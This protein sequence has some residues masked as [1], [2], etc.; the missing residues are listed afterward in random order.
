MKAPAP[1]PAGPGA[2]AHGGTRPAGVPGDTA[3]RPR[4]PGAVVT[5]AGGPAGVAV[6]QALVGQGVRVVAVDA[7]PA[8][9]G[10]CLAP[11]AAVVP[12]ATAEGFV[13]ALADLA[14]AR[15][16]DALVPTVA[17]ELPALHA[18]ARLLA[19]AG[20]ATWLP[21]PGA[22]RSCLDKWRFA[23]VMAAGGVPVPPT[24]LPGADGLPA[25]LS[26]AAPGPDG[27]GGLPGPWI[28]KPR[29]G[30]GSRHVLAADDLA[31][32]A[33]ALVLVPEPI[34][35]H[36]AAGREF[37]VDVLAGHDG[38]VGSVAR[39]RDETRGGISTRGE[40]FV[41]AGVDAAV[42]AAVAAAG[43]WGPA[44]V[45]GFA[46]GGDV[47][48]TEINPRFSGGLPLSLA[49]GADLVGEYLR[50]VR[51]Q[52]LRPERLVGRPGVQMRRYFAEVFSTAS[53]AGPGAAAESPRAGETTAAAVPPAAGPGGPG[54]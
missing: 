3:R 4:E 39:W 15:G 1:G 40:T 12:P 33:A 51:G 31:E 41:H 52:P 8:A 19:D 48:I 9:V 23:E 17:E 43:L 44:N 49:A 29:N 20:V 27:W 18:G 35:Q 25:A 21:E 32:L 6:V 34:V 11:E 5:G 45:Q 28:V 22:V 7:D 38:V 26:G 50:A 24:A 13:P 30:R 10:L 36:R 46:R 14:V 47:V 54:R 53:E 2:A 16:C 42:A 37:T